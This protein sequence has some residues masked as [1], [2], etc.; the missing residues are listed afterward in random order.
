MRRGESS[1]ASPVDGLE[2]P[3]VNLA[4]VRGVSVIVLI[5]E[6]LERLLG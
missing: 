6:V 3:E 2:H 1:G 5:A 4:P